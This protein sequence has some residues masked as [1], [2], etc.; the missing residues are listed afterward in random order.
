VRLRL[1]ALGLLAACGN[2]GALP[3]EAM[4]DPI[5]ERLIAAPY[6]AEP[7][8]RQ[9]VDAHT[10][11][12]TRAAWVPPDQ[13]EERA[14]DRLIE[15]ALFGRQK[16]APEELL[17]ERAQ[18]RAAAPGCL[19]AQAG[20]PVRATEDGNDVAYGELG[21]PGK[22]L[23]LWKAIRGHEALYVVSREFGHPPGGEEVRAAR[24]YLAEQ[25]YL[26]PI[27][28]GYGRCARR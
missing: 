22:S 17:A 24:A 20:A 19:M 28:G 27:T 9:V 2:P 5:T 23:V 7:P 15:E 1:V 12:G 6:P 4:Y 26:C 10:R 14:A 21:C 11:E 13:D 3:S 16:T 25:V 18:K 8:W